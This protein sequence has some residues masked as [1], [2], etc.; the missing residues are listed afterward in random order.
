MRFECKDNTP[1][2]L[3]A[4]VRLQSCCCCV[5]LQSMHPA[6]VLCP[7]AARWSCIDAGF[8]GEHTAARPHLQCSGRE[9]PLHLDVPFGMIKHT[10]QYGLQPIRPRIWGACGRRQ[11]SKALRRCPAMQPSSTAMRQGKLGSSLLVVHRQGS[12]GWQLW[13]AALPARSQRASPAERLGSLSI[14]TDCTASSPLHSL[15]ATQRCCPLACWRRSPRQLLRRW[16][17]SACMPGTCG[18]CGAAFGCAFAYDNYVA[19]MMTVT[20][21]HDYDIS[22]YTGLTRRRTVRTPSMNPPAAGARCLQN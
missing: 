3:H 13:Q 15:L 2:E 14:R 12:W 9:T 17:R 8:D 11:R 18:T 4:A 21:K 5:A 22:T 1:A 6:A 16:E 20:I 19:D 7:A 10:F